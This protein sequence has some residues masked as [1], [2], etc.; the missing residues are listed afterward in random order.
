MQ[1]ELAYPSNRIVTVNPGGTLA[2]CTLWTPPEY[3]LGKVTV[4][5]A[6]VSC[7]ASSPLALLGGLYGGG[8][9]VMLRNLLYNPQIDTVVIYGRDYSGAGFHLKYFF[10]DKVCLTGK[11]QVYVFDGGREEELEKAAIEGEG[12][13]YTMD[14]LVM[15]PVFRRPPRVVIVPFEDGAQG[16]ADFIRFYKKNETPL[17]ERLKIDLPVPKVSSFPSERAGH[18]VVADTILEAWQKLLFRLSRFGL[19]VELRD[20]KKR[21]EL[22]NVKVVVRCPENFSPADLAAHN[23]NWADVEKYQKN[24]LTPEKQDPGVTYT[25]GQR[26]G[27]YFGKNMLAT[28][29][30]DL[31]L[32]KDSRHDFI[33]TWDNAVDVEGEEAPCL[34][35]LFFRKTDNQVHLTATFRSHNVASAWPINCLGLVA[36]LRHVCA[37]ANETPGKTEVHNLR[38]G[39]LT[40]L[41]LS[42]SINPGEVDKVGG[43]IE[44]YVGRNQP[45]ALDPYGYFKITIDPQARE[46]VVHQFDHDN[47]QIAQYRGGNPSDVARHLYKHEAMSDISHALYM[48]SQLEK[49]WFCLE[50]GL[51]YEQDKSVMRL[52]DKD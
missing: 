8:L 23:L 27:S 10:E 36:V 34:V 31:S 22:L 33:T 41:S 12:T 50:H 35:S 16:L 29:A 25:Y 46:I 39:T 13:V 5:D 38:P 45:I 44:E 11:K 6:A 43:L 3:V 7:P 37:L 28:V 14:S 48:G 24:L 42:C 15:P 21:H 52:P 47:E 51:E 18:M 1:L 17:T 2:V 19:P 30:S 40:V 32:N 26:L 4:L 9:K 20:G 49:A